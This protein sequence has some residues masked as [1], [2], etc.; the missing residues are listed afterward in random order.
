MTSKFFKIDNL[1]IIFLLISVVFLSFVLASKLTEEKREQKL[2]QEQ[3]RKEMNELNVGQLSEKALFL[4]SPGTLLSSG[5][6]KIDYANKL[7]TRYFYCQLAKTTDK[8]DYNE[9]YNQALKFVEKSNL[10]LNQEYSEKY[11]GIYEE[12]FNNES[13]SNELA[14]GGDLSE[15]CPDK[16]INMCIVAREK[17]E[18]TYPDT[19]EWC[20]NICE[21]LMEYSND[22]SKL[23]SNV[24]DFRNWADESSL[25]QQYFWREL[26]AFRF[27]GKELALK[28]CNNIPEQEINN[29]FGIV[30][31]YTVRQIKCED[32]SKELVDL[33]CEL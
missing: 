16:L 24:V 7:T 1:L 26:M 3:C 29:C 14:L 33:I 23:F 27:G 10:M 28:V 19:E 20:L 8:E 4:K 22:E 9:I 25:F 13:F 15:I 12:Y 6:I 18:F 5:I 11:N 32:V 31:T 30:S 2:K 17:W 21:V